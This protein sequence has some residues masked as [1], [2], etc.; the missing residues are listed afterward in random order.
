MTVLRM[1]TFVSRAS[2]TS[3][4]N[5][6]PNSRG[7]ENFAHCQPTFKTWQDLFRDL[8]GQFETGGLGKMMV[9]GKLEVWVCYK[10]EDCLHGDIHMDGLFCCVYDEEFSQFVAWGPNAALG[11]V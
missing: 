7:S 10:G 9:V 8:D 4:S 5:S 3:S 2:I 1:Q 6:F 11:L